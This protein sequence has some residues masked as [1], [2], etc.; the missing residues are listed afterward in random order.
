LATVDFLA[1]LADLAA[2]RN[3]VR[4]VIA[5]EPAL[6]IRDGR[7]PVLDVL[8]PAG[9]F[10]PNDVALTADGGAFW[11]ITGPNMSGKSTFIRQVA[12]LTLLAHLGSFVPAAWAKIG[13]TDRIFTRVGASDEL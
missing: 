11:L 6:D 13:V 3:Y 7:H 5:D 10:V 12:L 9:M 8:L 1:S 4:P 2:A